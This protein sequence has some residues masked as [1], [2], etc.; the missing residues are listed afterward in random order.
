[1][2]PAVSPLLLIAAG[3][4]ALVAA[5]V[6]LRRLGPRGRIGRILAATRVV[7]VDEAVRLAQAGTARYVG[8]GG[9]LD[10][11]A[12]FT[13]ENDRPLVLRRSRLALRTGQRGGWTVVT[14]VREA[15]PFWIA[16]GAAQIAVDETALDH[17]LVVVTRESQGSAGEIEDRVPEGTPPATPARL[18]V[19]LLSTVDHALAL[20]VPI[21][22][23]VRG[24][25]LRPGLGRPLILTT[26]EPA[27]AMRIIAE[28][29][30]AA[31]RAAAV[32]LAS[33]LTGLGVG[34]VWAIAGGVR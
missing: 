18:Q 11:D 6:L 17:G 20:G 25:I 3:L 16:G 26:M 14:D 34:L 30:R 31:T 5:S 13:D 19:E 33:G 21:L 2:I 8:V 4:V 9:R 23:P 22:D 24:A 1:M 27:D 12:E 7:P 28:G 10:S 32:L 29:H 15:V